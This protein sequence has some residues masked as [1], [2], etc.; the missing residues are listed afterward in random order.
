MNAP[1]KQIRDKRQ[2]ILLILAT[3]VLLAFAIHFGTSYITLIASERPTYILLLG[4]VFLVAGILLLKRIAFGPTEHIVRLR[5]AIAFS[6][7]GEEIGPIEILGYAFNERFCRYLRGFLHENKAYAKLFAKAESDRA[8]MATFNPD[9]LNRQTIINSVIEFT[10]L[11]ELQ[12]HLNTYF[13]ENEIDHKR[14]ATLSREQFGAGVLKNRVI[15]LLTKDMKERSAFLRG[16]ELESEGMVFF[17]FSKDGAVYQRLQIE[18]PPKST[19]LRNINGFLVI[20]NPLFDLSIMPKYEGFRTT[21]PNVLMPSAHG[22]FA[23]LLAEV[24]LHIRIKKTV[25]V[26]AESIEMYEWLD[27][28]IERLYNCISLDRLT[29]RLDPD[30]I[31]LLKS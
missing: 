27:S 7:K 12:L 1:I 11:H 3:A 5:G 20:V 6:M 8:P 22:P 10:V 31:E 25:F 14:I 15:D 4:V 30:L 18:L 28:F 9:D 17:S 2:D 24:K 23:P 26:R 21:L 13:V 19:I 29:R 16:D